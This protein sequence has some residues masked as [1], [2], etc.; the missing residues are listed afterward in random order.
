[1]TGELA[2]ACSPGSM[3]TARYNTSKRRFNRGVLQIHLRN[4]EVKF[5]LAL[6][7]G[8]AADQGKIIGI[9]STHQRQFLLRTIQ[10]GKDRACFHI[11]ARF[12]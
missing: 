2:E 9:L 6:L 4:L 1:M 12:H 11:L 7:V 3:F 5:S 8:S 10:F